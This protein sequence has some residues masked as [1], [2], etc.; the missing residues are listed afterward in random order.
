M[1]FK[2]TN[3]Y[4]EL[5][6][7]TDNRF[8]KEYKE[9]ADNVAKNNDKG[10]TYMKNFLI[11]IEKVSDKIDDKRI[12][13]S[14]G[15][16]RNFKGYDDIKF[17]INFLSKNL[18]DIKNL[19]ECIKVFD[20]LEDWS[21][22]YASGYSK[23]IRLIMHEYDTALYMLV[24]ALSAT[25]ANNVS[26]TS[27]GTSIKIEKTN[28]SSNTVIDKTLS[29]LA[30]Q[31]SDRNHKTY[32][33]ELI[34]NA[35]KNITESVFTEG[36][37]DTAM[38]TINSFSNLLS[39][40][41]EIG[42][43]GFTLVKVLV[44]S[45]FGII[46]ITRSI[47]YLWYKRKADTIV[48]L[49]EQVVFIKQNIEFLEKNKTIDKAQ[50]EIIIKKQKAAIEA[51]LKKAAK[52]RAQLTETERDATNAMNKENPDLKKPAKDDDMVLES[53]NSVE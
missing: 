17:S 15:N 47:M 34:D 33:E 9:A 25:F 7:G 18:K 43:K 39:T 30:K 12:S 21:T 22:L 31:L 13:D 5:I 40:V 19:K 6:A 45:F 27:N 14:K 41:G 46:P 53:F 20:A 29:D 10:M 1:D 44:K 24:T 50:K 28:G 36:V 48:A 42:K 49:E 11:S 51:R 23:N 4:L 8:N 26:F 52:L 32:L 35:D 16:V 3:D 38:G 37:L 2:I